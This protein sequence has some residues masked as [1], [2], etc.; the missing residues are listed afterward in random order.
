MVQS[1]GMPPD[2]PDPMSY[3]EEEDDDE[4]DEEEEMRW[5]EEQQA[6][7]EIDNPPL[8]APWWEGV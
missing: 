8:E 6:Q 3:I 7:Y 5:R 1:H 4:V 2:E